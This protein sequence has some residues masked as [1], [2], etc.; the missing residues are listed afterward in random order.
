MKMG[1][2][3]ILKSKF[4]LFTSI[5]RPYPYPQIRS[6]Q[7]KIPLYLALRVEKGLAMHLV[8]LPLREG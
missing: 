6:W 3:Q 7:P 8:S 2:Y 5:A 1:K 4:Q